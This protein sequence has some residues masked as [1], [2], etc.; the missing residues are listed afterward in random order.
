MA[1]VAV[2]VQQATSGP[3]ANLK[4]RCVGGS[5]QGHGNTSSMWAITTSAYPLRTKKFKT[6]R[7][8]SR[9]SP[10]RYVAALER[11]GDIPS[12]WPLDTGLV[13]TAG[14]FLMPKSTLGS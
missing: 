8:T 5:D 6:P 12:S 4:L 9:L 14:T 1:M 3:E 13:G 10:D 2:L 11:D 7:G